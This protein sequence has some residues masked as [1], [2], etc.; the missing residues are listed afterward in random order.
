MATVEELLRCC[1]PA[2]AAA[3][4]PAEVVAQAVADGRALWVYIE[5]CM[6]SRDIEVLTKPIPESPPAILLARKVPP[7]LARVGDPYWDYHDDALRGLGI[8]VPP[9]G[10]PKRRRPDPLADWNA[11]PPEARERLRAE[12]Q[13]V[14]AKQAAADQSSPGSLHRAPRAEPYASEAGDGRLTLHFVFDFMIWHAAQSGS[15]WF[16]H[17]VYVGRADFEGTT[18]LRSSTERRETHNVSEFDEPTYEPFVAR[19]HLLD[20]LRARRGRSG[21][22]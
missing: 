2:I 10:R 12:L 21:A 7:D 9:T 15:D 6:G 22:R 1:G 8:P 5:S 18:L 17:H 4:A 14:A 19:Q 3:G 20:V 16:D 13:A 11:L